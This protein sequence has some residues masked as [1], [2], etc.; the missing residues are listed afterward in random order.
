MSLRRDSES[1]KRAAR[2]AREARWPIL[3][4]IR[5]MDA[6]DWE[7]RVIVP[8]FTL[9]LVLAVIMGWVR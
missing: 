6:N 3:R 2:R 4:T 1:P 8:L 9:L 7:L 5:K